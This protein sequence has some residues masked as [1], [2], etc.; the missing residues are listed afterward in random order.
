MQRI[1]WH[2]DLSHYF[3]LKNNDPYQRRLKIYCSEKNYKGIKI[4]MFIR[5][6]FK[7]SLVE[8]SN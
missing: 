8:T 4:K 7:Q 5:I 6:V 2:F 3:S 1:L